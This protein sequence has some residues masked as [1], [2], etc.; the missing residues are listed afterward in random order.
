MTLSLSRYV[1][2]EELLNPSPLA[3]CLLAEAS[4]YS[5]VDVVN[6]IQVLI[7]LCPIVNIFFPAVYEVLFV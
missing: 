7:L 1:V 6:W 4:H 5:Q 2:W 3:Q